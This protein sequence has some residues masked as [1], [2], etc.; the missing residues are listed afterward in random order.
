M[1]VHGT[2]ETGTEEISVIL[3]NSAI[4]G[5]DEMTVGLIKI[6][7]VIDAKVTALQLGQWIGRNAGV[8]PTQSQPA[9][10]PQSRK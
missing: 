2:G 1:I 9:K 5:T 4:H 7:V 8:N 10:H 3:E 6:N